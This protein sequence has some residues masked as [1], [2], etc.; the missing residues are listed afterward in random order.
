MRAAWLFGVED[1]RVVER[2]VTT[3]G[4]GEVLVRVETAL[5]CSTDLKMFRRGSHPALSSLPSPFGHECAGTIVAVGT[6]ITAL[7]GVGGGLKEGMRVVVANSAPCGG[8]AACRRGQENL[9]HDLKFLNGAYAE[10]LLVPQRIASVNVHP[11]PDGIPFQVAAF[12]EPLACAL[13]GLEI[14]GIQAGETVVILG[15]GTLGLMLAGLA[16][17]QG[18]RPIVCDRHPDRLEL[19]KG[20]G[21]EVILNAS[22]RGPTGGESDAGDRAPKWPGELDAA[23]RRL[24]RD[25]GADCVIE[26]VGTPE[27]WEEAVRLVR[28]GGRVV[29]FGGCA[30]GSRWSVDT[31]RLHYEELTIRGAFH[32][33]PRLIVQA[34]Q[35][36]ARGEFDP[37]P[38]MSGTFP[39]ERLVEAFRAMQER[40]GLKYL[41]QPGT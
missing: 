30:L 5:T 14:A 25:E 27:T 13:H 8:C 15:G 22:Q 36:L 37:A 34:L 20:Y 31:H 21:A 10:Y 1:V 9:C 18:A 2:E 6:G 33:A 17:Q 7:Q 4:P 26:A 39:L 19:A 38:L 16:H 24:Q 11:L 40:H 41:I 35:L 23:V 12:S 28:R 32:H 3:P 29:L